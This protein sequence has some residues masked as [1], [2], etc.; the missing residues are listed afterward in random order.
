MV[1][2]IPGYTTATELGLLSGTVNISDFVGVSDVNDFYKFQLD[3]TSDITLHLSGLSENADLILVSSSEAF[4]SRNPGT[5]NETIAETLQPGTYWTHVGA[6]P[7]AN[8]NYDLE[9]T[10]TPV[11][12]LP[13]V[14]LSSSAVVSDGNQ[15]E[16]YSGRVDVRRRGNT[17]QPLTV[18]FTRS[19]TATYFDD[20][21]IR[22][23]NMRELETA[24]KFEAGQ[25]RTFFDFYT[26][27][28]SEFEG[29]EPE[30]ILVTL[31]PGSGY[32]VD[33]D[34]DT[35]T[36]EIFDNDEPALLPDLRIQNITINSDNSF[37]GLG[38]S[39]E[40]TVENIGSESVDRANIGFYLSKDSQLGDD[41]FLGYSAALAMDANGGTH[42]RGPSFSLPG[43]ND[44]FWNGSGTYTVIA[45]AD[46]DNAIS[47]SNENNNLRTANAFITVAPEVD[48]DIRGFDILSSSFDSKTGEVVDLKFQVRN[49]GDD[50][51]GSFD[52]DFF[53]S[54]D[55]TVSADDIELGSHRIN[56]LA[57]DTTT[58]VIYPSNI[59]LPNKFHPYWAQSG[60]EE[61]YKLIAYVDYDNVIQEYRDDNNFDPDSI[62]VVNL[63][64]KPDPVVDERNEWKAL[65]YEWN[66]S[67]SNPPPSDIRSATDNYARGTTELDI[68]AGISLG[69][70]DRGFGDGTMGLLPQ[71]A[72]WPGSP[73]GDSDLPSDYFVTKAFTK[74]TFEAGKTYKFSARA[75][76][77][78]QLWAK[79]DASNTWYYISPANQWQQNSSPEEYT[80]QAPQ[81]GE[82]TVGF[83][84]YEVDG[85]AE[86][87]LSWNESAPITYLPG[88]I[89][90]DW[91]WAAGDNTRITGGE[92]D[93]PEHGDILSLY[94][95][96]TRALLGGE[97]N[98]SAGYVQDPSY[99]NGPGQTYGWHDGIDIDTP[100]D[101][102]TNVKA[103]V[104]GKVY[105]RSSDSGNQF[106]G[107]EGDDGRYYEYGHLSRSQVVNNLQVNA[108][109]VIGSVGNTATY[110]NSH[111][112]HFQ[113]NNSR[114][115]PENYDKYNQSDVYGW[116]QNPLQVFWQ[117]KNDGVI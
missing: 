60:Y 32:T 109:D 8:T 55:N 99:W 37:S 9:L 63:S 68:V 45:K 103:L 42:T 89:D 23:S 13:E 88:L 29:T 41:Y 104:G 12:V 71:N 108:G 105:I 2:G 10:A 22:G 43:Y 69:T 26:N 75:D 59:Q 67:G 21:T 93:Y 15:I 57:A 5:S 107:I 52:V 72:T 100:N 34:A 81:S 95:D 46:Y 77:G 39:L 17:D 111:H 28:D 84:H 73:G 44:P 7:D 49:R 38:L 56:G 58:S 76:D 14:Y 96:L 20:Y 74:D 82:Y 30:T 24:V 78:Y 98:S 47:E 117:L 65:I 85:S 25:N 116:T 27:D 51:A 102:Y 114:S 6:A 4:S 19:G 80:F 97:Y 113:V 31:D 48:L 62:D 36:L 16:G 110:P 54:L 86:M 90:V 53:L 61:D 79:H 83:F 33:S 101:V 106:I 87:G 92:R 94:Y 40:Y 66:S 1:V 3:Q 112:L 11:E 115:E 35:V 18:T 70:N 91:D 64:P 50:N